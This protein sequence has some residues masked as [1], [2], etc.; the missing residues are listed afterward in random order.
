MVLSLWNRA[1]SLKYG[2]ELEVL[3][4]LVKVLLLLKR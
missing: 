4:L 1:N 3:L 2:G